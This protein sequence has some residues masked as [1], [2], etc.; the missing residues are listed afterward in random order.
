ML[1]RLKLGPKLIGG[2]V[3]VALLAVFVGGMGIYGMNRIQSTSKEMADVRIPSIIS[4]NAISENMI[5]IQRGE[6]SAIMAIQNFDMESYNQ[7]VELL[8]N[9]WTTIDES[10]GKYQ[11]IPKSTKEQELWTAA[12]EKWKIWKGDHEKIMQLIGQ[13]SLDEAA[14]YSLTT[15]NQAYLETDKI[16]KEL[17]QVQNELTQA[18]V[19]SADSKYGAIRMLLGW[20]FWGQSS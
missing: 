8:K 13:A 15:A 16:I 2:F 3:L 1:K 9:L 20:L 14:S 4:L 6:R 17:V 12:G 19:K 10:W 11:T 18:D 7:Q 5:Q